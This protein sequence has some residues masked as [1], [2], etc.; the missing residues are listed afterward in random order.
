MRRLEKIL[1]RMILKTWRFGVMKMM[2]VSA[3]EEETGK[4]IIYCFDL[5]I[6]L[7][8]RG[9]LIFQISVDTKKSFQLNELTFLF[10]FGLKVFGIN[11][12]IRKSI[13][14]CK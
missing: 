3:K 10:S 8:L 11:S 13:F 6:F 2:I 14:V 1:I 7:E 5:R 4:K 9:F 12:S